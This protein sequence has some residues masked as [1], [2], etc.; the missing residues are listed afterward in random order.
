MYAFVSGKLDYIS[1]DGLVVIDNHGMGYNVYVSGNTLSK[2]PKVGDEVKLYTYLNVKEDSLTLYGFL[3]FDEKRMFEKLI[4]ING[5]GCKM[6]ISI[7]SGVDSASLALAIANGDVTSLSRIKG[8]GKKTAERIIL[9]LKEKVDITEIVSNV[10]GGVEVV[11]DSA[12]INDAVTA[13]VSL[14]IP[15]TE[16]YKAVVKASEKASGVNSLITLALRSM[17]R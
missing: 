14:G 7:L 13:L 10:T 17:D 4:N 9:E 12:D 16:A 2:M 8:I 5:V 1:L 3:N 15:K 6:A 11:T